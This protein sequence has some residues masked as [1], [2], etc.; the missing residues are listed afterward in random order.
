MAAVLALMIVGTAVAVLWAS[1]CFLPSWARWET[2]A[3]S[4]DL[5]GDGA[6]EEVAWGGWMALE[7]VVARLDDPDW[8]I[9][10]D[11]RA[12]VGPWLRD[13]HGQSSSVR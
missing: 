6:D 10:P 11:S 8:P 7:D 2:G 3:V 4:C 13:R 12:L 1:G 5:D 9:V